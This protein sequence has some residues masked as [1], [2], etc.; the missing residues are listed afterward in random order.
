[1]R[2]ITKHLAGAI[3]IALLHSCAQEQAPRDERAIKLDPEQDKVAWAV[4]AD[5]R[6]D[7]SWV[8]TFHAEIDEGWSVYS[9][10]SFGDMGPWP[11]SFPFDSLGHVVAADGT[12]E[13]SS[14]T[15]QGMDAVF[16]MEVKKFKHSVDF[17][18]GIRLAA[19]EIPFSGTIEYMTCNDEMCLPPA[20]IFWQCHADSGTFKLSTTPFDPSA[21]KVVGCADGVYKLAGVDLEKPVVPG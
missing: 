1:M 13:V 16:G 12:E 7:D 6:E 5:L 4:K 19:P 17:K 21:F 14:H 2:A 9:T 8:V 18:R 11:S 10:Q 3:A 20:T 15:V